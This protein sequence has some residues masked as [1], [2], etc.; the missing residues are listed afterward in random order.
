MAKKENNLEEINFTSISF[1]TW[2]EKFMEDKDMNEY[3]PEY[4]MTIGEYRKKIY[5]AETG[6]NIPVEDFFKKLQIKLE[7]TD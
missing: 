7:C 4:G 2:C 5:E 6:E 3:I 1:E